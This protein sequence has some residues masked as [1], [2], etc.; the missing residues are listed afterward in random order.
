[1]MNLPMREN[2]DSFVALDVET[3]GLDARLHRVVEIALVRFESGVEAEAWSSLVN[4][5]CNIPPEA[6]AIHGI[7]DRDAAGAPTFIELAPV[8]AGRMSGLPLLAYNAPFDFGFVQ[9]EMARA[10]RTV[11]PPAAWLDPLPLVR[12]R[13]S[14]GRATLEVACRELGVP[15]PRAH[16][17]AADARAAGLI[18]L[19]LTATN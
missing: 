5:E 1:M 15:L 11:P 14:Y 16:R 10:G 2:V 19:K 13:L 18:W 12:A 6:T 4:P 17:A 3:T 7:S 9:V 8:I